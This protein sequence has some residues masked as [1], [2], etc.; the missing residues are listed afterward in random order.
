[1]LCQGA[2]VGVRLSEGIRS[3]SQLLMGRAGG[4]SALFCVCLVVA[5]SGQAVER[6]CRANLRSAVLPLVHAVSADR[7]SMHVFR[8]V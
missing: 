6:D 4:D 7:H 1:M 3:A 2:T 5:C 8:M